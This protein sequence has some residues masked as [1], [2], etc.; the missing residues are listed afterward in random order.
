MIRYI[1]Y[2]NNKYDRELRQTYGKWV[3]DYSIKNYNK[4]WEYILGLS[5]RKQNGNYKSAI[6]NVKRLYNY[7]VEVDSSI[8]GFISTESDG[9]YNSLHHHLVLNSRLDYSVLNNHINM[10]WG[11]IGVI[12]LDNYDSNGNYCYY[13]CKHLNK[14]DFNMLEIL[15]NLD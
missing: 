7:L 3:K 5:Y 11:K 8:N 10:F 2:N 6:E 13:M 4:D 15:S 9:V 12:K 1:N 14:C